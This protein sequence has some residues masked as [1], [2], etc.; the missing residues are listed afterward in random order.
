[1]AEFTLFLGIVV[2][3]GTSEVRIF[4]C[5]LVFDLTLVILLVC[6]YLLGVPWYSGTIWY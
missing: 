2:P 3:F 5:P 1:L 4:T 6:S